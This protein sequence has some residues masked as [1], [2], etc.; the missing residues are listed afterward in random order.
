MFGCGHHDWVR[1]Y[2]RIP[3]LIDRTIEERGGQRLVARGEGDAGG[4]EFFESF[5]AW[6][7]KLWEVLP[8]VR[9][10][11]LQRFYVLTVHLC[12]STTLP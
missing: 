11:Y 10:P 8:G 3:T 5:D 6:E 12:R 4:A 2:Q 1:T 9:L 7:A